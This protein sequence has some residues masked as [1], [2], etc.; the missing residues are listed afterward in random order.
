[1]L[2]F[3]KRESLILLK[4]VLGH[5]L[6]WWLQQR[7]KLLFSYCLCITL[8][9]FN[10]RLV[11][12]LFL[13]FL[14]RR[15]LGRHHELLQHGMLGALSL[16]FSFPFTSWLALGLRWLITLRIAEIGWP[17]SQIVQYVILLFHVSTSHWHHHLVWIK[18]GTKFTAHLWYPPSCAFLGLASF[19][20]L[21]F[22]TPPVHWHLLFWRQQS[23]LLRLVINL[24][25]LRYL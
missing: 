14:F 25:I 21:A 8:H 7:C 11:L 15:T 24:I 23:I 4:L 20:L 6:T 12:D 10:Y 13:I 16:W 1:M 17:T 3:W 18:T 19:A 22:G 5:L 9:H 2:R